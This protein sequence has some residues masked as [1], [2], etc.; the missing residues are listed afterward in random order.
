MIYFF[1]VSGDGAPLL[2]SV[3][4]SSLQCFHAVSWASWLYNNLLQLSAKILFCGI[5]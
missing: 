3:F 5:R 2:E 4:L 1:N